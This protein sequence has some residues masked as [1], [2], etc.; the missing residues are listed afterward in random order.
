MEIPS[1]HFYDYI[2]LLIEYQSS[3]QPPF[4][5]LSSSKTSQLDHGIGEIIL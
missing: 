2:S 4:Q 3:K 1:F 5:G